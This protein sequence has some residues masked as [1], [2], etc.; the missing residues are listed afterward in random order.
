MSEYRRS[1]ATACLGVSPYGRAL[2]FADIFQ[3]G[4]SAG[5]ELNDAYYPPTFASRGHQGFRRGRWFA[6]DAR[7]EAQGLIYFQRGGARGLS[8]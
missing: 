4:C 6:L 3:P 5:Y 7:R 1:D 2:P 8:R